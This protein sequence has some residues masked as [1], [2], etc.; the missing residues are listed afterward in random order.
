MEEHADGSDQSGGTPKNTA[1]YTTQAGIAKTEPATPKKTNKAVGKLNKTT[2][3]KDAD[4]S[5][6]DSDDST[7]KSSSDADMQ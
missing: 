7:D 6:P 3:T 4:E 2:G 5:E 1:A